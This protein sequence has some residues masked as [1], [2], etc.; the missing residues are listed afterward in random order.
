[1]SNLFSF[2]SLEVF[3]VLTAYLLSFGFMEKCLFCA[4][5]CGSALKAA[6]N[7]KHNYL[8]SD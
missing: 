7:K 8:Q 4:I 2:S 5:L 1:M 6:M 3:F